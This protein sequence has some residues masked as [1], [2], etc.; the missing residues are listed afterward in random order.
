MYS[1]CVYDTFKEVKFW[2]EFNSEYKYNKYINKLKY[3]K[4][5]IVIIKMCYN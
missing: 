1:V 3:S 4:R 5:F 2:K